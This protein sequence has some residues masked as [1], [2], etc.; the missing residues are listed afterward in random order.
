MKSNLSR[1]WLT[2]FG[3]SIVFKIIGIWILIFTLGNHRALM[4]NIF[5]AYLTTIFPI[6][7]INHVI[8][9]W[10]W[11]FC[12]RAL[13]KRHIS[14]ILYFKFL[15]K[16]YF[17]FIAWRT[18]FEVIRAWRTRCLSSHSRLLWAVPL[19]GF[20]TSHKLPSITLAAFVDV[21]RRKSL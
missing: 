15:C 14:R 16:A 19:H 21:K 3:V 9:P 2:F 7:Y 5:R 8:R 10:N 20:K 18:G 17:C 13:R 6:R 4:R 1:C 12:F 11:L